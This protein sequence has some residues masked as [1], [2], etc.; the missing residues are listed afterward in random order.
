MP[1]L[2]IVEVNNTGENNGMWKFWFHLG[3]I[4]QEGKYSPMVDI[5]SGVE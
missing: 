3:I 2:H 1:V 5:I 4:A